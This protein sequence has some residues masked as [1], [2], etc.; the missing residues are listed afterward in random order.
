[1]SL[2][3][4]KSMEKNTDSPNTGKI[5]IAVVDDHALFREGIVALLKDYPALDVTLQAAS[6]RD[7]ANQLAELKKKGKTLPEIVLLDLQMPDMDGSATTVYLQEHYPELRIIIL[8]MFNEAQLI[9]DLMNK[10]ASGFLVKD[11]SVE[12]VVEVITTVAESG[13]YVDEHILQSIVH[14]WQKNQ[15]VHKIKEALHLSDREHTIIQL[16]AEQKTTREIAEALNVSTRTVDLERKHI[17]VKTK[18]KNTAGLILFAINNNLL[19]F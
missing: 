11:K 7:L 6:G 8:T 18:T 14:T 13:I 19:S 2:L 5:R 12:M 9:F 17:Y 16:L 1:M 10:G 4:I 3:A 15:D